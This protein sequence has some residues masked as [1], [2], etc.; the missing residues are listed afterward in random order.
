MTIKRLICSLLCVLILGAVSLRPVYAAGESVLPSGTPYGEIGAKLDAYV[1]EHADT[2]AGLA[3]SVFDAESAVCTGYYGCA[4]LEDSLKVDARTVFEWGSVSKLTVWVSVMQ[5]WE[6]GELDLN[7]DIRAYLPEGFLKNLRYEKPVTMLD[8]M[9]HRAGF[10]ELAF[11]LETPDEDSVLPLGEAL[12]RFQPTQRFEPGVV[13][14]YSNYGAALAGYIVE[15][16][17]GQ[18]YAEYVKAHIFAPLGMEH[19]AILPDLSDNPWVRTQREQLR[20]YTASAVRIPKDR[21]YLNLY[22][23]GMC[24]STLEDLMKFGQALLNPACP[25]FEKTATYTELFTPSSFCGESDVAAC[26]HGFWVEYG[27]PNVV[28]HGGNTTGCTSYLYLDPESGIGMAI[29]TNQFN[30]Q[31]YSFGLPLLVFVSEEKQAQ[32]AAAEDE[33]ALPEDLPGYVE[34]SRSIFSGPLKLY[35]LLNMIPLSELGGAAPLIKTE[36]GGVPRY[37]YTGSDFLLIESWKVI[38][39]YAS[40]ALW[41]LASLFCLL[42]LLIRVIQALRHRG[43]AALGGWEI[44]TCLAQIP[45]PLLIVPVAIS[46]YSQRSWP[47]LCYRMIFAAAFALCLLMAILF[48]VGLFR[49]RPGL[50]KKQKLL[51]V[52]LLLTLLI[53]IGNILYWNVFMFWAVP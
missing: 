27:M 12:S 13:Q 24:T 17:S 49:R 33:N 19:T 9:N 47:V 21:M 18:S 14:A 50:T 16:V 30:E 26:C 20:S 37:A 22:P 38:L 40:V 35:R 39:M 53:A 44:W 34:L 7:E 4:N 8:L 31:L 15:R 2:T 11:G 42:R 3:V 43:K 5:L 52:C 41:V 51:R 1:A 48:V 46:L 6:Q 23:C 29:M 45:F 36:S 25:L 10:E 32:A 28:G